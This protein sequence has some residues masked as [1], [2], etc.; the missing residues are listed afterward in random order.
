MN[1]SAM[2]TWYL[3]TAE[4]VSMTQTWLPLCF[5]LKVWWFVDILQYHVTKL[6]ENTDEEMEQNDN[7]DID[8]ALMELEGSLGTATIANKVL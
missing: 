7:K 4:N 6:S 2:R 3:A 5:K 8:Q 1:Y